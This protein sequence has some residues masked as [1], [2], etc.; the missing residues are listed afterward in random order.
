MTQQHVD[1]D[2]T[3]VGPKRHYPLQQQQYSHDDDLDDTDNVMTNTVNRHSLAY[4]QADDE[5]DERDHDETDEFETQPPHRQ[6]Q[7]T[8]YY[9]HHDEHM[10]DDDQGNERHDDEDDDD[11][12]QQEQE[13]EQEDDS[14]SFSSDSLSSSPSIPDE[15]IDFSLVY[16]LHTFLATVD[17]QASV[18]KGDKLLLL[19]D[20]NS[21]WWLVRVLKTQAV[22]YIPAENIETPWER[23]ARLNKHR[24]VDLTTATQQDV[25]TGPS[26]AIAQ[27]RFD[28]R[29]PPSRQPHPHLSQHPSAKGYPASPSHKDH[30]RNIS[31][32][33]T[34]SSGLVQNDLY[35]TSIAAPTTAMTNIDNSRSQSRGGGKT[36]GFTAPVYYEHSMNGDSYDDDEEEEE[37]E[38]DEDGMLIVDGNQRDYQD[39]QEQL[40]GRQEFEDDEQNEFEQ[41]EEEEEE[42]QSDNGHEGV[43]VVHH[44]RHH[45]HHHQ[46]HQVLQQQGHH[47]GD[48]TGQ[49]ATFG[50][51]RDDQDYEEDTQGWDEQ[52]PV[53]PLHPVLEQQLQQQQ[54]QKQQQQQQTTQV[55]A[56]EIRGPS[57]QRQIQT[58]S[59][60]PINFESNDDDDNN[61]STMRRQGSIQGRSIDENDFLTD[62]SNISTTNQQKPTKKLSAT[63][64]IVRDLTFDINNPFGDLPKGQPDRGPSPLKVRGVEIPDVTDPRYNRLFAQPQR[65]VNNN[66]N[67]NIVQS[68]QQNSQPGPKRSFEE[69]I[70][71]DNKNYELKQMTDGDSSIDTTTSSFVSNQSTI[72]AP[73]LQSSDDGYRTATNTIVTNSSSKKSKKGRESMDSSTDVGSDKKKKSGLLGLF[74]KKDKKKKLVS[75]DSNHNN[76]V[77]IDGELRSSEESNRLSSPSID[78]GLGSPIP[79]RHNNGFDERSS[80]PGSGNNNNKRMS[81]TAESM[82]GVDAALRQ[83]QI[84]AKQ[85]LFH[86]YG[87]QRSPGDLVNTMTPRN[88]DMTRQPVGFSPTVGGG[89]IPS[90]LLQAPAQQQQQQQRMRPGSLIGSPSVPGLVDVPLLNVMRVF[91]GENVM[92]E[93]TFKT[94][95]L[96]RSTTASDL[97]KQSM[98]RFRLAGQEDK[99]DYYLTVK[100]LGE[101]ETRLKEDSFPLEIFENL[102]KNS[103]SLEQF[104]NQNLPLVK[105][106]S[107]GSINSISSNLSLNPAISRLGMNDWSDDTAVKFYLN[108]RNRQQSQTDDTKQTIDSAA[109]TTSQQQDESNERDPDVTSTLTNINE[110]ARTIPTSYRFAVQ[111]II[112]STDLPDNVT[113]DPTTNNI[114]PKIVLQDRL[115]K[116]NQTHQKIE[117][118]IN[119]KEKIIF[120]PKNVNVADVI[121]AGL[122]RFG[123]VD[124]VVDGGDEVE[125]RLSKRRS[126]TRVKY[127][128]TVEREGQELPLSS[129][130]KL[131]DSYTSPP[132]F[133]SYDR[134]S[135]EF[136]RRSVDATLILGSPD[137]IQAT[138]PVFVL[139]RATGKAMSSRAPGPLPAKVDELDELREQRQYQHLTPP[140]VPPSTETLRP[141]FERA[142]TGATTT[143]SVAESFET[144]RE[145]DSDT[146]IRAN[147]QV[148]TSTP[149]KSGP[150]KQE[151]IA[152]QREATRANQRAILSAQRNQDQGVDIN[153]P[154]QGTIRSARGMDDDTVRYS[155]VGSDGNEVDISEIV[156]NEW[157]QSKQ[158]PISTSSAST[159]SLKDSISSSATASDNTVAHKQLNQE[160]V[161]VNSATEDEDDDDKAAV[162]ALRNT[163]VEIDRPSSRE[164]SH[165]VDLKRNQATAGSLDVLQDAIGPRVTSPTFNE[166]LQERLDRVLAKV[167]EDRALGKRPPSRPRSFQLSQFAVSGGTTPN[168]R[169]SPASI[170]TGRR[171]PY[172]D[173]GRDSPTIDQLINEKFA[174]PRSRQSSVQ[175]AR[176]T[177]IN[178]IDSKAVEQTKETLTNHESKSKIKIPKIPNKILYHDDFG[179]DELCQFVEAKAKAN[180]VVRPTSA[181]RHPNGKAYEM[182]FGRHLKNIQIQQPQVK[183]L[184]EPHAQKLDDI[185]KRLDE[186]LQQTLAASKPLTPTMTSENAGDAGDQDVV[187]T[188]TPIQTT[189]S[190]VSSNVDASSPVQS[191]S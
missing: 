26:S 40:Q 63:P 65:L 12:D 78:S 70:V 15:D 119:L 25:L 23:L 174:L 135:K 9:H 173:T 169:M 166:T 20:S 150:T 43:D 39:D 108:R 129:A 96:N 44:H 147:T 153:I 179:F 180:K 51:V 49:V 32:P 67:N 95:L 103:S 138:D 156:E 113:F 151:L 141:S 116:L 98:Q 181:Y 68:Q 8:L 28:S 37:E 144:A 137:D 24:N 18:V 21:Y 89:G 88:G 79:S 99:D 170:G 73:S 168:G 110:A 172:S 111:I 52:T 155:F 149:S 188:T 143:S 105:R 124:G 148:S 3:L 92:S 16:A 71:G 171:S 93:S 42:D 82:F 58:E 123:I 125:D 45:Q 33:L 17:G 126:V 62:K 154:S 29:I 136:R 97:V 77:G 120:F 75:T 84:E 30:P 167:K 163:N 81:Q 60:T 131:L 85:A 139:R 106:S 142:Q 50:H 128:L 161:L 74:R 133:K 175:H 54:Q 114:I 122:D 19:D 134:S 100:E 112:H 61:S 189:K 46:H 178:S 66:N 31:P 184:F 35:E 190:V 158:R 55:S 11:D 34:H 36:V 64:P 109:L 6:H 145:V 159:A 121:E 7:Q 185:E 38:Y 157:R 87:V 56:N 47:V 76:N 90:P 140:D 27:T 41:E 127:R 107:I 176:Q 83:Q 48:E 132:I 165:S 91:A 94:V 104:E 118:E 152:A 117:K 10:H 187:R 13:Q 72:T 5:H 2:P 115:K 69:S 186:L 1:Q 102:T 86:Q 22:G 57:P 53:D 177:S 160:G 80:V 164:S 4:E 146:L 14:A 101:E 130:S 162:A 183:S 182:L 191:I 59:T